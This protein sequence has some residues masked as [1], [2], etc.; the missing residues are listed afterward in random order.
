MKGIGQLMAKVD[1]SVIVYKRP[2]TS[3]VWNMHTCS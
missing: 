3:S 2:V 1:I